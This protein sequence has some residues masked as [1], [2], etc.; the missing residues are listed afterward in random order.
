MPVQKNTPDREAANS[1]RLGGGDLNVK[2]FLGACSIAL[3]LFFLCACGLLLRYGKQLLPND[4]F[5]PE[6]YSQLHMPKPAANAS[7]AALAAVVPPA[8]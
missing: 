4:H 5:D 2:A 8:F 7:L 3:V 6:P 1:N